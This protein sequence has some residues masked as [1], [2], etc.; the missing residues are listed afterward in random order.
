VR[1]VSHSLDKL[2][3]LLLRSVG[4]RWLEALTEG[5]RE[6]VMLLDARGQLLFVS[7]HNAVR[8]LVGVDGKAL[9][10]LTDL[11]PVHPDDRAALVDEF[12]RITREAGARGTLEYRVKHADG[13]YVRLQST[14]VNRLHDPV[15][16]AVVVNT[17]VARAAM[18]SASPQLRDRDSF[19]EVLTQAV[20]RSGSEGGYGFSVLMLEFDRLKMLVGNYGQDVVDQLLGEVAGRLLSLLKRDDV[21]ADMGGGE[22]AALLDGVGD[23]RA[24]ARIADRIQKTLA[25]R[26]QI[27]DE[28]ISASA[29]VGIATSE[30]T[31]Q[32]AEHV[33]RDAA[34]ATNRARARGR[35]RRAVFQTQMRIEDTRILSM[36]AAL[37][38]ALN[39]KQFQLHYQP[40]V[41]LRDGTLRGFE[42]LLRWNHPRDGE[43]S[44]VSFIPLAEETGLIIPLGQWVLNEACVQ[45][46]EWTK[47]Y[48]PTVPL[49]VS[50][51]L[52]AKQFE[53][54][55]SSFVEQ[56]LRESGLDPE[57]LK[58][59][60]TESAVLENREVAS[61]T[62]HRLKKQGVRMSLDDFGTGY[63]SFSYLHQLPYDTLKIDRSFISQLGE[64]ADK[65][66]IV[67]AIITLAHNLRM[68]VVAEGV[69]SDA[70]AQQLATMWCE[71]GQGFYFAEPVDA[72]SAGA[73]ISAGRSW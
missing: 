41:S 71:Y 13:R 12:T 40:I 54:D 4:A 43:I 16:G 62:L 53:D 19:V 47:S 21:L 29:I 26:Y 35:R 55:L 66:D 46:V 9:G 5:S 17:R 45:M 69:E 37:H 6:V 56:T 64:G 73:M 72:Q 32:N 15:V 68:D 67:H 60:V 34:L 10:A 23:R 36:V 1:D 61:E 14:A 48:R 22:F 49:H 28:T 25:M 30:R 59:E 3:P 57:Q 65:G 50:V 39:D 8:R 70:Q 11:R 20:E 42:A 31:Y 58:L 51:N 63:S 52:S 27:G 24:A 18:A 33:L 7:P 44:P 2:D 38:E